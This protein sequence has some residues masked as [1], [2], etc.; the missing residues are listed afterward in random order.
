EDV[1]GGLFCIF[2]KDFFHGFTDLSDYPVFKPGG[3]HVYELA[4]EQVKKTG[5]FYKRIFEELDS[6]YQHKDDM[7]RTIVFELMHFAMKMEPSSGVQDQE[8]SASQRIARM[9]QDL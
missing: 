4:D 2:D 5:A 1:K 9:F 7:L 8:I 3:N 6:D